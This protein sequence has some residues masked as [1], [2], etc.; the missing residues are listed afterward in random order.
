ME[1]AATSRKEKVQRRVVQICRILWVQHP[2]FSM[3][4]RSPCRWAERLSRRHDTERSTK[5][6][7]GV[8]PSSVAPPVEGDAA[9]GQLQGEEDED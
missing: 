3:L 5:Y 9:L 4:G 2:N 1:V 8:L 7:G 6:V